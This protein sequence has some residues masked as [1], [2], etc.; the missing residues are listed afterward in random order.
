MIPSV[1]AP[2]CPF[3]SEEVTRQIRGKATLNSTSTNTSVIEAPHLDC[4]EINLNYLN[5]TLN[6]AAC[7][8][9]A[10]KINIYPGPAE[11]QL[12]CPTPSNPPLGETTPRAAENAPYAALAVWEYYATAGKYK[13]RPAQFK[14]CISIDPTTQIAS[15]TGEPQPPNVLRPVPIK[16][17]FAKDRQK[18]L[19]QVSSY[20][21]VEIA[22]CNC[23]VNENKKFEFSPKCPK[24]SSKNTSASK[25]SRKLEQFV[26]RYLYSGV[27]GMEDDYAAAIPYDS[28][29]EHPYVEHMEDNEFSRNLAEKKEK[30]KQTKDQCDVAEQARAKAM[31]QEFV[32]PDSGKPTLSLVADILEG[33]SQQGG[34][35]GG[36]QGGMGGQA[37]GGAQGG[38]GGQQG[39]AGGQQGE[40]AGQGGAAGEGASGGAGGANNR[41]LLDETIRARSQTASQLLLRAIEEMQEDDRD[42]LSFDED[43]S[44]RALMAAQNAM[45]PSKEAT[46]S[47]YVKS[48]PL[49]NGGGLENLKYHN[50][51]R[52]V[53]ASQEDMAVLRRLSKGEIGF[54]PATP[55]SYTWATG[56]TYSSSRIL[57]NQGAG[58]AGAEGA[59]PEGAGGSAGDAAAP[60]GD[61]MAFDAR[62]AVDTL[63]AAGIFDV[64]LMALKKE[65]FEEIGISMDDLRKIPPE[66]LVQDDSFFVMPPFSSNIAENMFVNMD[67]TNG[68]EDGNM[69]IGRNNDPRYEMGFFVDGQSR[70]L[71]NGKCSTD[72]SQFWVKFTSRGDFERLRFVDGLAW[73]CLSAMSP[74]QPEEYTALDVMIA[75]SAATGLVP[76][77]TNATEIV[78][79]DANGTQQIRMMKPTYAN[80]ARFKTKLKEKNKK[81]KKAIADLQMQEMMMMQGG[82]GQGSQAQGGQAQGGQGQGGQPQGG[83]P[84]GGQPQ[85]GQNLTGGSGENG[86]APS[87]RLLQYALAAAPRRLAGA[88]ELGCFRGYGGKKG[89]SYGS[90]PRENYGKQPKGVTPN[91]PFCKTRPEAYGG[92]A[93][94]PIAGPSRPDPAFTALAAMSTH[95]FSVAVPLYDK[96]MKT[97]KYV[98]ESTRPTAPDFEDEEKPCLVNIWGVVDQFGNEIFKQSME[99]E[100]KPKMCKAPVMTAVK[101]VVGSLVDDMKKHKVA[102]SARFMRQ[103]QGKDMWVSC[104]AMLRSV[105][106]DRLQSLSYKLM[107]CD[108]DFPD[109][110]NKGQQ[111]VQKF[112]RLNPTHPWCKEPCC[113]PDKAQRFCCAP[114]DK[115]ITVNMPVVKGG[116]LGGYCPGFAKGGSV[117]DA[118]AA[119]NE[120][121]AKAGAGGA[122]LPDEDKANKRIVWVWCDT[123]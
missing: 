99:I 60:K 22:N 72:G 114:R 23:M 41:R 61:A 33:K 68:A 107:G 53:H 18:A 85:G 28:D 101:R 82:Q 42:A 39:G 59:A 108:A 64:D 20:V 79:I 69:L 97:G 93:G 29:L 90:S 32:D 58:G 81:A 45:I 10:V 13:K 104:G 16:D 66:A 110:C 71:P 76:S 46:S 122:C 70:K 30:P 3:G 36:G 52:A 75:V 123:G 21:N 35:G 88:S 7:H 56:P 74:K 24:S 121:S 65:D 111:D 77:V 27:V 120:Y 55:A 38:A 26:E 15:E 44:S 119:A 92:S 100:L 6:N 86:S 54:E 83:Q 98:M 49:H 4:A 84:Q 96:D 37:G 103:F 73:E 31:A 14:R 19:I 118:V 117:A 40:A 34:M 1:I 106:D 8:K 109:T 9:N 102:V 12:C 43:Q 89:H 62:T 116:K 2:A 51:L 50:F 47:S 87:S 115:T 25:S 78:T 11:D 57:Q 112:C 17:I 67:P 5:A 95:M 48:H 94:A 113:N 91:T 105:M 63:R 80:Y